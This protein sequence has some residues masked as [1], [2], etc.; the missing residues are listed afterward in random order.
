MI[1]DWAAHPEKKPRSN[2]TA[3]GEN[4]YIPNLKLSIY[5]LRLLLLLLLGTSNKTEYFAMR[6]EEIA[7][8]EKLAAEKK[9]K[10]LTGGMKYTAIA[11]ANAKS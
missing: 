4:Y 7:Q 5:V 3:A 1:Q 11:M 2:L 6:Q 8:R 10:Y 9:Q